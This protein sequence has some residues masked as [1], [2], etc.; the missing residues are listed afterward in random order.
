MDDSDPRVA[1]A[2]DRLRQEIDAIDS[3]L[4]ELFN[5]RARCVVEIG[6]IKRARRLPLYQPDR[7]RQIFE[8]AEAANPGPL[9]NRAI[10]RLFERVLDESRSVERHV[11]EPAQSDPPAK[12]PGREEGGER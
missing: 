4:V 3:R 11:M 10:R 9:S 12:A 2:I 5:Q 7:E 6:H 1:E 8:R